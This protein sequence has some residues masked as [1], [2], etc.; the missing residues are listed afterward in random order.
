MNK[1]TYAFVDASNLFYGG[2]KS[3]GWKIDYLK[4]I[5]Y[6][7]RKYSVSEV[8]YFGGVEIHGYR[9]DYLKNG[10]VPLK[11]LEKKLVDYID[12]E[13]KKIDEARLLLLSRHLQRIKFYLKLHGFGYRLYL[14]PV[15]IYYQADGRT[16]RKAN[17]DVEMA[18]YLM[19]EKD[20]FDRVVVLSGDGDFLPLLKHLKEI[21]KE[22]I[23]LA[24]GPRTAKEIRQ[25]AGSN[26]RD[27]VRL[28]KE[29][30]YEKK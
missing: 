28:E 30:K 23:I 16:E 17:C 20:N 21:G 24:R 14:K 9:Y 2:E 27:F 25:F 7:K 15:K 26:F 4:L 1:K 6:L 18:F 19:K 8:F 13:G 12:K 29:I 3:L 11:K 5:K 10:T 22:V